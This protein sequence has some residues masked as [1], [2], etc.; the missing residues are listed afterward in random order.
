MNV[1]IAMIFAAAGLMNVAQATPSPTPNPYVDGPTVYAQHCLACH[2]DQGQGL[3]GVP[4]L[5]GN[6]AVTANDPHNVITIIKH[7]KGA[8]PAFDARLTDVEIAAVATYIRTA[9]GN[10][11]TSVAPYQVDAVHRDMR[12]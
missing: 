11:G 12:P 4:Q 8:M 9:W 6:A 3:A 2:G 1:A 7:G 5:S 10:A